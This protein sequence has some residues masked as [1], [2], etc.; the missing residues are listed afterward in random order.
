MATTGIITTIT[1]IGFQGIMAGG[2][3]TGTGFLVTGFID[4]EKK[5]H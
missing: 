1:G 3:I 2:I 5:Q 4:I